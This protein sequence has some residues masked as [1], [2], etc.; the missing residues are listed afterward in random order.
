MK[1]KLLISAIAL[2]G[3]MLWVGI[4]G[5][6]LKLPETPDGIVSLELAWTMD[7]AV[8]VVHA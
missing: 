6:A 3:T 4:P 1:Q 7:S 2:I 8:Q 5:N